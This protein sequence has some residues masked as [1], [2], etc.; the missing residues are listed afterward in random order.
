[1]VEALPAEGSGMDSPLAIGASLPPVQSR[2]IA[3]VAAEPAPFAPSI[4]SASPTAGS[5]SARC[6]DADTEQQ[7]MTHFISHV[8]AECFIA[9][10]Q[11]MDPMPDDYR[12]RSE[13]KRF[14]R[15]LHETL[16]LP[17]PRQDTK[18]VDLSA[19]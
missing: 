6:S 5:G 15:E 3:D 14:Y 10:L 16:E 1:M 8:N 12:A 11:T 7:R 17:A 9:L 18:P 19:A 2:S 4:C 13:Y